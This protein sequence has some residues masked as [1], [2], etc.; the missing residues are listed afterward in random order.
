[1]VNII[2]SA[3]FALALLLTQV[4]HASEPQPVVILGATPTDA[5]AQPIVTKIT[6]DNTYDN[7][8]GSLNG[9]ACSNGQFGLASKFPTFGKL[10]TFPYIGG[11]FNVVWNS[12][13]C[14]GCWTLTNTATGKSIH[15]IAIDTAGVGFNVAE[16][17]FLALGG[18]ISTGTA[19]VIAT[20]N[21]PAVCGL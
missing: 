1:M 6:Y 3:T 17:A 11:A 10:P 16:E 12:P 13:N 7:K 21:S 8:A 15:Y 18:S 2:Y 5:A 20:R 19:Q 4:V 14:G 9:V